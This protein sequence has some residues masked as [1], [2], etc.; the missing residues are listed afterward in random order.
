MIHIF[1]SNP[2]NNFI[3]EASKNFVNKT[4]V[5]GRHILLTADSHLILYPKSDEEYK[6][7]AEHPALSRPLRATVEIHILRAP[8][9]L[10]IEGHKDGDVITV[11][12]KLTLKC[13]SS[14]G[15]PPP[16]V[17]WLRNGIEI[18]R[19]S[20]IGPRNEVINTLS[21]GVS[22]ADN[23]SHYTCQASNPLTPIPLTQTITLSVLCK[24][25]SIA[26][27]MIAWVW[28]FIPRIARQ[29]LR[30]QSLKVRS[31]CL[32]FRPK[33]VQWERHK[34]PQPPLRPTGQLPVRAP[35]RRPR[36]S[37]LKRRPNYCQ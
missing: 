23:R 3:S 19:N 11:T 22:A 17:I 12:D 34:G 4:V 21:I 31:K 1:K 24:S 10:V 20:H 36:L 25:T 28:L 26:C 30:S 13:V 18:D 14:N 15:Y 5:N 9:T 35:R 33:T 8:N 37:R 16:G 2:L 32:Y 27:N 6:C 29:R 7:I